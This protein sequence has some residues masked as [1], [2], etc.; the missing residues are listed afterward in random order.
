MSENNERIVTEEIES[1][2][3]QADMSMTIGGSDILNRK[4]GQG[5]YMKTSEP[6]TAVK[7]TGYFQ[8]AADYIK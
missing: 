3:T 6:I 7:L 8:K 4:W 5:Y 2:I 1:G